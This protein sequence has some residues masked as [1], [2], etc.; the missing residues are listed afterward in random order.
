[1]EESGQLHNTGTLLPEEKSPLPSGKETGLG[2]EPM[3][4][5]WEEEK[6]LL[7]PEIEI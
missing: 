3:P 2:P 1:M 6:Y 4:T 5:L 7:P